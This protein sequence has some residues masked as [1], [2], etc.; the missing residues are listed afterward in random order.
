M[1]LALSV[2]LMT[3]PLAPGDHTRSLEVGKRTR[4][5]IVHVPKSYEGSKPYPVVLSFHGGGS[6]AEGMVK[7][8]D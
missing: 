7:F 1:F 3:D 6:N 2:I 5:Y 4:T 8:A